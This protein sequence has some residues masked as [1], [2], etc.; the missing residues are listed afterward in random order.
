[1]IER[2]R[3]FTLIELLVTVSIIGILAAIA[4]PN[5]RN[6]TIRGR[7]ARAKMDLRAI[8]DSLRTYQLD[9][10]AYPRRNNNLL[11]FTWTLVPDLTTPIA[12]I[13]NPDLIDPFGPVEEFDIA[14]PGDAEAFDAPLRRNSYTYVPYVSFADL[15]QCPELR[16]EGFMVGSV[17]PDRQDSFLVDYP[18]PSFRRLPGD[19]VRDS[20]YDP[21]NG[22][23]SFGDIGYFG[24][25]LTVSGIIG[26]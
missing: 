9:H 7:V 12:Y 17:G 21:S 13:S 5:Y 26:G 22:V 25:D 20:V 2:H 14:R 8:G 15:C 24:G 19:S 23:G 3:G 16:R 11:F 18:F 6:A 1:M 10:N 4:L